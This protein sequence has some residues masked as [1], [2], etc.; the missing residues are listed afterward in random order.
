[1]LSSP[2][3]LLTEASIETKQT[4]AINMECFI[5]IDVKTP[6]GF[7]KTNDTMRFI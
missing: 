1:M 4:F 5:S 2:G 3:M 7:S 6:S